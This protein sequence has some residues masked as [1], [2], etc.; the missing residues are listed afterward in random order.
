[1]PS[2]NGPL[3]FKVN[4]DRVVCSVCPAKNGNPP[5]MSIYKVKQHE[6]S[7]K[8]L[9]H[10]QYLSLPIVPR[11]MGAPPPSRE[12]SPVSPTSPTRAVDTVEILGAPMPTDYH[13]ES[14]L[15]GEP[16]ND[17]VNELTGDLV[18]NLLG[19]GA[20]E[21]TNVTHDLGLNDHAEDE[22]QAA[23]LSQLWSPIVIH[24]TVNIASGDETH[25]TDY[26][27]DMASD[28]DPNV[29]PLCPSDEE[30]GIDDADDESRQFEM[31]H[32]R[33]PDDVMKTR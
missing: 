10:L 2:F 15:N 28:L 13:I 3:V 24:R 8:H 20:D 19:D 29:A 5:S 1:M 17:G 7:Q 11:Y 16:F 32:D 12:S 26:F 33:S 27:R 21:L 14:T 22:E 4:N 18:D 30:V 31:D 23:P 6:T 9:R 25:N